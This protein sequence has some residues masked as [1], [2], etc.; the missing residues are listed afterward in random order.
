M[1]SAKAAEHADHT[2]KVEQDGQRVTCVVLFELF[3]VPMPSEPLSCPAGC[4][5]GSDTLSK[6]AS[7]SGRTGL[8]FLELF[9]GLAFHS[10]LG[11][12]S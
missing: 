2:N 11:V 6:L 1:P 7:G 12:I 9:G 8:P 4:S 10:G 3:L 5:A